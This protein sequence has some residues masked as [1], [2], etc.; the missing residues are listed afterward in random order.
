MMG[1]VGLGR[2]GLGMAKRWREAGL[3]VLGYDQDPGARARAEALGL[4]TAEALEALMEALPTPRTLWLMVPAGAVDP[5]LEALLPHLAPGDLVVDG[6]NS[7]YRESQRRGQLLGAR[8]VGFLDVGVS[9]GLFGEREGY[10]IMVGGEAPLVARIQPYLEA[11]APAGGWVH[12]GGLGA[13]HYAKMVHNGIEY[14]LMEAYAEGTDL[15]FAA[16]EDLGLD[17]KAVVAAWR[18][19]T[20]VRGFLL[21]RLAEVLQGE[22]GVAPVVEDTGEGRWA[23]EEGLRRGVPLPAMAQALFAR[24]ESQGR[25]SLRYRLQALLRKAFGG[26][27]VQPSGG[28]HVEDSAL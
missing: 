10:G 15:L 5:L 1:L 18:R 14:A 11:L 19:G 6:G 23:L 9:G 27:P 8:G 12:A 26:H 13:G 16:R 25:A 17:P 21:D 7:F 4:R 3:E 24:W 28:E 2:M 20:I 22:L